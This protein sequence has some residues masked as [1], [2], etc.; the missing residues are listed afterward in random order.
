MFCNISKDVQVN[1]ELIVDSN[2]VVR[3][4]G[5]VERFKVLDGVVVYFVR[6][7]IPISMEVKFFQWVFISGR[8][9]VI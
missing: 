8:K 9:E 7:M 2:V 4:Q 5:P 3:H 1:V 6:K